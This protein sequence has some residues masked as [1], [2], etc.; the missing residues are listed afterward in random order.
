G[1]GLCCLYYVEST[2]TDC[3][4]KDNVADNSIGHGGGMHCG[5]YS[6]PTLIRCTF[7]GN[8][9]DT[10]GGGFHCHLYSSATL[11]NCTFY[12]NTSIDGSQVGVRHNS[13]VSLHNCIIAFGNLGSGIFCELDCDAFLTCCDVFGNEGGDWVDCI[14]D[15]YGING[16]IAAD[17]LFCDPEQGDLGIQSISPCAPY[18]PP[19]ASCDLIGAWPVGCYQPT[20]T[21]SRTWG[22]LKG[23]YK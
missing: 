16:N 21:R 20:L 17:P 6:S 18:S 2:V 4:F 8:H 7:Q 9:A 12:D 22:T 23:Y 10:R 15:Q 14:G 19:N 3:V 5:N 13:W 1:G 11:E